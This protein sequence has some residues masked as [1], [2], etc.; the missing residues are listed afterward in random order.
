MA[1]RTWSVERI[2]E[3]RR[4]IEQ[5]LSD[6][7]IAHT[8][9]CR[10]SKIRAVRELESAAAAALTT[11]TV[12]SDPDWA[13]GLEWTAILE[14]L[15]RG[16]EIKRI[17]EERAQN[18]TSYS[19]FWKYLSRRHG[20]CLKQTV[21]LREFDPG[22]HC[23]V[24]WA[25]DKI[26]WWDE[27]GKRHEAH[28]FVGIL[29]HSQ[30]LFAHALPDEKS[31]SW[32]TAHEKMF[33]FFK[34]VPRVTVPD[35]LRTGVKKAHLYDPD[36]NPLYMELA[37]HYGTAVVPAR[38]RKHIYA[39][40]TKPAIPLGI[41]LTF[42]CIH[43]FKTKACSYRLVTKMLLFWIPSFSITSKPVVLRP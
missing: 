26:P 8:M 20:W 29:C 31:T 37:R 42:C 13:L 7:V 19:N 36:L 21:T 33:Q 39:S 6:R 35:N 27:K 24:D 40:G 12:A 14:E 22:T 38:V 32:L 34:G 30:L 2:E 23:E 18:V 15:G 4:Y 5:G 3:I 16:F 1:R 25:G 9:R 17:W 43:L 10:R 28:V 41:M 11:S